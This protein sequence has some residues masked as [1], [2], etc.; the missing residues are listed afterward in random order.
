MFFLLV[1][2]LASLGLA[3]FL[4]GEVATLPARQREGNLRRASTY[5][6]S[7]RAETGPGHESFRE[8]AFEP[9]KMGLAHTVLKLSPRMTVDKVSRRLMGAGVGRTLSPTSFLA[10]KAV[11]AVLGF[12]GGTFLGGVAGKGSLT[13][14]LALL[15]GFIGF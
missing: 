10:A 6:R 11:F 9:M 7:R 12:F 8:R 4:V 13:I 1:L 3:A 5:G 2:G 14:L 15:F